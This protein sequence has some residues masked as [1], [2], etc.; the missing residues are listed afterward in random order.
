[1][2]EGGNRSCWKRKWCQFRKW[3]VVNMFKTRSM[4]N[5]KPTWWKQVIWPLPLFWNAF[6]FQHL[7]FNSWMCWKTSYMKVSY[8]WKVGFPLMTIQIHQGVWVSAL[9]SFFGLELG[10]QRDVPVLSCH[11]SQGS[12]SLTESLLDFVVNKFSGEAEAPCL[13]RG[14]KGLFLPSFGQFPPLVA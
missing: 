14:K 2:A 10:F 7:D 8:H 1:M 4:C 13:L 3:C 11:I 5:L 9:L 6:F 12:P